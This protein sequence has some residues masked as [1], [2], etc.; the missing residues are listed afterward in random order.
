M[1]TAGSLLLAS[2]DLV[3]TTQMVH[4]SRCGG[5]DEDPTSFRR[6]FL[7]WGRVFPYS[8]RPSSVTLRTSD[9]L[10]DVW[11]VM[12]IFVTN[13]SVYIVHGVVVCTLT[14]FTTMKSSK[15]LSVSTGWR[16][17][18]TRCMYPAWSIKYHTSVLLPLLASCTVGMYVD[19]SS[20]I[21]FMMVMSM[22]VYVG[23]L[24]LFHYNTLLSDGLQYHPIV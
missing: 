18:V 19:G 23:V 6:T 12:M 1:T 11:E 4:L 5:G 21:V 8:R 9:P 10:E 16:R 22:V 3:M 13:A 2:S 7:S 14:F 17:S 15:S 20:G 24:V